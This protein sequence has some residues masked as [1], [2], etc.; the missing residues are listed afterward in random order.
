MFI[1]YLPAEIEEVDE[2]SSHSSPPSFSALARAAQDPFRGPGQSHSSPPLVSNCCSS[3]F[4]RRIER[5]TV[6]QKHFNIFPFPI[7]RQ[8]TAN[9]HKLRLTELLLVSAGA[10]RYAN[11]RFSTWIQPAPAGDVEKM[12]WAFWTV[13]KYRMK[14]R[15]KH[16]THLATVLMNPWGTRKSHGRRETVTISAAKP[17]AGDA[18]DSVG[19]MHQ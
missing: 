7:S 14:H 11:R 16:R 19:P 5:E 1:Q 10:P 12:A 13:T 9:C 18:K 2:S 15:W 8:I 4:L 3:F 17:L 6:Q